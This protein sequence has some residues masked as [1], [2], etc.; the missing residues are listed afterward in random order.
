MPGSSRQALRDSGWFRGGDTASGLPVTLN[1]TLTGGKRVSILFSAEQSTYSLFAQ[2]PMWRRYCAEGGD[3]YS[4]IRSLSA[5]KIFL[6]QVPTLTSAL[7]I[8]EL[9]Y[10]FHSFIL[11]CAAFLVTWFVLDAIVQTILDRRKTA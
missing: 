10:K 2:E 9:F 6:E 11:E 1:R 7:I 8:A 3:M 5:R 4:L